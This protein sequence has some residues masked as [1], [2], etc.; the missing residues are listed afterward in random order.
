MQVAREQAQ[1]QRNSAAAA[2]RE[3]GRQLAEAREEAAA[4]SAEVFQLQE[5]LRLRDSA[6]RQMRRRLEGAGLTGSV[7][8]SEVCSLALL[9]LTA[10]GRVAWRCQALLQ[11][12][13]PGMLPAQ[14]TLSAGCCSDRC[15]DWQHEAVSVQPDQLLAVRVAAIAGHPDRVRLSVVGGLPAAV[16]TCSLCL[17]RAWGL[18]S[19]TAWHGMQ[20]DWPAC[21][22]ASLL[23]I[24]DSASF[25]A[26]PAAGLA[27][28]LQCKQ[29]QKKQEQHSLPQ[30]DQVRRLDSCKGRGGRLGACLSN[31]KVSAAV[32]AG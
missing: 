14:P 2:R 24:R 17:G 8:P 3:Q 28:W 20:E 12:C 6:L 26:L 22:T 7:R 18:R 21:S 19:A 27:C 32:P 15:S 13:R 11:Q 4:L 16:A 9:S 1:Q 31:G 29:L 25:A 10:A 30:L 23:C 5:M